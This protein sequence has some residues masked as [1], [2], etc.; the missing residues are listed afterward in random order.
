MVICPV[1]FP[2]VSVIQKTGHT[3]PLFDEESSKSLPIKHD[4]EHMMVMCFAVTILQ[5]F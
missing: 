5:C 2:G 3:Q 4:N 1:R